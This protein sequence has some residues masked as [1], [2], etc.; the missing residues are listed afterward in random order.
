MPIKITVL[1]KLNPKD[2]FGEEIK[3]PEGKVIPTCSAFEEGQE[4]LVEKLNKPDKFCGWAWRDIYKD[5]SVLNFG[6]DF[7][8]T[9]SNEAVTCCTDGYRPVIFK[10]ERV[11]E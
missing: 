3:N 7:P 9:E 10:I 4:F 8:W 11:E 1:K 6:G 2:I 5:V